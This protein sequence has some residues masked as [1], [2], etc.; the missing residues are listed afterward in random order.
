MIRIRWLCSKLNCERAAVG[1][2]LC[3][4]ARRKTCDDVKT[5]EKRW[6]VP[7]NWS[8]SYFDH[9]LLWNF[10]TEDRWIWNCLVLKT[11]MYCVDT[12]MCVCVRV[13]YMEDRIPLACLPNSPV[14]PFVRYNWL[15]ARLSREH[16]HVW[17]RTESSAT[18]AYSFADLM[19][20]TAEE[21]VCDHL[22]LFFYSNWYAK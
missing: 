6:S 13:W 15:E 10:S 2:I 3:F 11:Q 1:C 8:H 18:Q 9:I 14:C 4:V 22:K 17:R 20:D 16:L 21:V 5:R 12:R 7:Y 19:E